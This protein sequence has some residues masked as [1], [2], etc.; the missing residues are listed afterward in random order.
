[1]RKRLLFY[2]ILGCA[3]ALCAQVPSFPFI[4]PSH[5]VMFQGQSQPFQLL[6][7]FGEEVPSGEW[8]TSDPRTADL[9][10]EDGHVVLTAKN[11]GRVTLS[12]GH[13]DQVEIDIRRY[14]SNIP[15]NTPRWI[16]RPIDGKFVE[17]MWV[18]QQADPTS[19][20]SPAYFYVDRG[21][22][23]THLRAINEDGLQVWQWPEV[24]RNESLRPIC[25]D[26]L[27]GVMVLLG[28]GESR[29]LIDI[30]SSGHE[31]WHVATSGFD[32]RAYTYTWGGILYYIEEEEG[33]TKV[34]LSGIDSSDGQ[35]KFS[36]ELPSS[37]QT[38]R[39]V[40]LRNTQLVCSPGTRTS[41]LPIHH[42][43]LVSDSAPETHLAY[44]QLSLTIDVQD[45]VA[46]AI[47][48]PQQ[49]H[50]SV[51]QRLITFEINTDFEYAVHTVE[52]NI[53]DGP[54]STTQIS[55]SVPS[56]NIIPGEDSTGSFVAIRRTVQR[57]GDKPATVQEFEYR[58][59]GDHQV[60]YRLQVPVNADERSLMCLGEHNLGFTAH[61]QTVIAFNTSTAREI[62]RWEGNA[63][64]VSFLMA[65]ADDSVIVRD[66]E[67]YKII[68]DGKAQAQ[69]D[70]NY[71]PFVERVIPSDPY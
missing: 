5:V 31:R 33:G 18:T 11:A 57:W 12:A 69:L 48:D 53:S 52:E 51:S 10:V 56:G 50:V 61:G 8:K 4:Q 71:M 13:Q 17:A 40:A 7:A 36:F 55:L 70:G 37:H 58:I 24:P 28:D 38:L 6:N 29:L 2:V 64:H 49:A 46:G 54:L 20:Q 21:D 63:R 44:S 3:S 27:G 25:G 66:G 67:T 47:V 23:A 15:R 62:W 35:Q 45:C 59:T 32:G 34:R 16:L 1:M 68:R 26:N 43:F 39:N 41:R 14:S 42:S 19:N 65:M 60:K 30:D 9:K 22:A